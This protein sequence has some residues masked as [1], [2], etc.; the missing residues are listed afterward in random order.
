M[1]QYNEK[2]FRIPQ[3][4]QFTKQIIATKIT[5]F[6]V[7]NAVLQMLTLFSFFFIYFIFLL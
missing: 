3:A 6:T 7:L 4:F 5:L 2:S 1:R